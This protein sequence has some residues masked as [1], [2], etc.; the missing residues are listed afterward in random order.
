MLQA[1][2]LAHPVYLLNAETVEQLF[3]SHIGL[4]LVK[5]G[6]SRDHL[7]LVMLAHLPW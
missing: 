5:P 4:H 2:N 7:T 3:H 6:P 1:L